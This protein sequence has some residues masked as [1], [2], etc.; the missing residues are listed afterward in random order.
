MMY[1]NKHLKEVLCT[2]KFLPGPIKWDSG[3]FGQFY[4]K[5][6]ADGFSLRQEKKGIVFEIGNLNNGVPITPNVQEAETQMIFR[7][8]E[9]NYA[10]SMGNSYVTFHIVNTYES[11]EVFNESLMQPFMEKYLELGIY[12]KIQTCQVVYLNSFEIIAEDPLSDYFTVVSPPFNTFGREAAVQVSK[13]YVA[14]NGIVLNFKIN[15]QP[16]AKQNT[17]SIM[18]ECGAVGTVTM[19]RP[20]S[21]WKTMSQDIKN[22]VRDFFESII[23]EKLRQTL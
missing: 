21:D 2:F 8:P 3:F 5:I 9:K 13:N 11:W 22:P 15:P 12:D 6:Q 14:T 20:I 4:D 18:L 17:K 16:T 19:G 7:N 10:I 1:S 23:T